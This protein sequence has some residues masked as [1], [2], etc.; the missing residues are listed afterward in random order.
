MFIRLSAVG[1]PT[2]D[3]AMH[4]HLPSTV[5]NSPLPTYLGP[6]LQYGLDLKGVMEAVAK[7]LQVRLAKNK[8]GAEGPVCTTRIR[9]FSLVLAA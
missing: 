3:C 8:T 2:G 4:L 9:K 1:W 6:L 7:L 5:L